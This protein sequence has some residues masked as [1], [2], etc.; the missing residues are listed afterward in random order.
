MFCVLVLPPVDHPRKVLFQGGRL[1]LNA[2]G[3]LYQFETYRLDSNIQDGLAIC[4]SARHALIDSLV[5]KR[6]L[7]K[8]YLK[9]ATL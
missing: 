9:P 3:H 7:I 8:I 2:Y 5:Y 4:S 6:L 1:T